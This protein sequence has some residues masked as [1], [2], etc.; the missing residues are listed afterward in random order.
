MKSQAAGPRHGR[1]AREAEI[2]F[3]SG[4]QEGD[5]DVNAR[6]APRAGLIVEPFSA[7]RS[8][9]DSEAP[10]PG[11]GDPE[12]P[13]SHGTILSSRAALL[14]GRGC[15]RSHPAR[16]TPRFDDVHQARY[17]PALPSRRLACLAP[18]TR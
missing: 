11:A 13:C 10:P 8:R 12:D 9:G 16:A 15:P 7:P 3:L 18:G 2:G 1:F 6:L 4:L 17:R 5:D 14:R